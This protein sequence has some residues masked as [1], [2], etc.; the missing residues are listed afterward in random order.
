M[1][2]SIQESQWCSFLFDKFLLD[3][4]GDA[5]IDF[6]DLI[7]QH[8]DDFVFVCFEVFFNLGNLSSGLLLEGDF[9]L[10]V[11]FLH[12]RLS[13]LSFKAWNSDSFCWRYLLTSASAASLASFNFLCLNENKSTFLCEH[14]RWFRW[15]LALPSVT[16]QCMQ[17]RSYYKITIIIS[18]LKH[19]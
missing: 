12:N 10:F 1:I 17:S 14:W 19:T 3:W 13:T 11:F 8:F 6:Q 16:R 15:R 4:A 5:K 9:E 7:D 18:S 2:I